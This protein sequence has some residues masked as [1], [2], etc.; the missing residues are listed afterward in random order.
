MDKLIK[1]KGFLPF[2][3]IIF[4]NAFVDLGHKILIQNTIFKI[5]DGQ[6]QIILTAIVNGLI[7]LPFVLLLTPAGYISDRFRKPLI[8]RIS[9]ACAVGLALLITL[10]YH[11]GWF[12][13]AF[14]MTFLLAMQSAFYSPA[15]YGYIKELVGKGQ[16][17]VANAAVQAITIVAILSGI[18]I[19]SVLFEQQLVGVVYTN[20]SELI[21]AIY[22]IGWVLV[23]CAVLEFLAA[24][25]LPADGIEQPDLSF[26]WQRY[27]RGH[28]LKENFGRLL[29]N[30]VIWLSI[31][32]LSL[33]WGIAQVLLAAFPA[34]AK[35]TLGET[36][37]VVIQ[38]LL[39]VNGIGII[40]GSS[41][42]GRAS[43]GHIETG[44]IPLGAI[45]IV[46][47]LFAIPQLT[48]PGLLA[49]DFLLLGISGGMFI[50]PLN[51][52]IQFHAKDDQLGAILAGSNWVQNLIMLSFLGLTVT[53]AIYGISSIGLFYLLTVVA[54][55]GA[56]YTVRQLPQSL[57]RFLVDRI[58]SSRYAIDVLG[59][60]NI[61]GQGGVLM[62]GNHISWLD[63]AIIQIAC[64]RPVRFV[65]HQGI[66]QRWY[67]KWFLDGFGVVPIAA[68]RSK[69]ALGKINELLK[70]G[71][72]IC[73]FPEGA[74]SRN[75]QLGE[76]K[77]GYERTTEGVVGS[78]LP[79]YLRGLWGSR[80]SRSSDKL[81]Q[82]RNSRTRRDVIVAFGKPL[83]MDTSAPELKRHVFDLSI[84]AWEEHTKGLEP[85]PLAW[86][87]TAKRCGRELS[88]ADAGVGA[89]LSGYQSITAVIGFSRLIRKRSPEQNIGLLLPTSTAG[90]ITNM[91]ILLL[92]KTLVNLNY[93]ANLQA[94]LGAVERADIQS[95]YTSKRFLKKLHGRGIDLDELLA[96]VQV[97]YLE[98]MKDELGTHA[99]LSIMASSVFLPSKWLYV[100]FGRRREIDQP[101]AILFSSGSEGMPKG[102]MLSHRN[103]MSNIKQVSDVLDIKDEDVVMATLPLFHAFGLTVTGLMPLVEGVPSI[104]H[105]DPTDALVIAKAIAKNQATVFCGTSTFLR[106]FNRNRRIHPL[107]LESLR[108][109]VAGAERL[110]P[111]VRDAFRLKFNKEIYEGYGATETTPVASV[112][113]PDRIDPD[114]WTIQLGNKPGTVGMPLPG[115]S[116][117]IVD[118]DTMEQLPQGEDGL[119]LFG[120]AQVMLGYLNDPDKTAEVIAEMDDQRWYKTG[121]KGHLDKD[122]FLIIVDRYSRFAKIGGEMISLGAI[123][124]A[125]GKL[126]PEEAEILATVVP[127]GKKGEKVVLLIAGGISEDGVK[128]LIDQS[129]LS[130]LMRP[131]VLLPV[132]AIPKL[133]SGKSDFSEAKR[134]ALGGCG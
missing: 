37:T 97:H 59:F 6:T 125:I 20:E 15:K 27:T 96:K 130:P 75:G 29:A 10:A 80:F 60:K 105:P 18:F 12:Q 28:S 91:A 67:L 118:P 47:A 23:A 94:L 17:T 13:F 109:V 24:L 79:F 8:I 95:I 132:E 123:E 84:D 55:V 119:I 124:G 101:A 69:E 52:L 43:R 98:D 31:V 120:G 92:G 25:R 89:S 51:A 41:L 74:I 114:D 122:G 36:N 40:I 83:P 104:L 99:K 42:A 49:L 63:W 134:I 44:L 102:V 33:F 35:E 3:L 112:N 72:V 71:E 4:F 45:G 56:A 54:V 32:G 57:V 103:I 129:D 87:R 2:V 128:E 61:P 30:R 58:V 73:L 116:F 26:D 131:A 115:G 108:V 34:F 76:F 1:I 85:I 46:V 77:A 107:M 110:N 78:I 11:N 113:V 68:G 121:D 90:L 100:L 16:L 62:L 106:L 93:T 66:Y 65:M 22:P 70:Q 39:A 86:L 53:F 48:S 9:A 38:G 5:Y 81:Q 88:I 21:R 133:G 7:L 14:A 82:N 111:E 50:V 117:R 126:L 127:D 64:P 19:Y